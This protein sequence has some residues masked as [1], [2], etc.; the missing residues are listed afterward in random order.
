MIKVS[1]SKQGEL[2][3]AAYFQTMEEAQTWLD[4][5]TSIK[6]F[7]LAPEVVPAQLDEEGNVLVEE[8]VIPATHTVEIADESAKIAAEQALQAKIEAGKKARE[9]CTQVLDL[10]SGDNLSKELTLEQISDMQT[11]FGNIEKALQSARPSLAK[12]MISAVEPD[13]VLI[14][15]ELK[16]AVLALLSEY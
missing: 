12:M 3:N 11:I 13:E 1:I 14:T 9:V 4:Y 10:I 7:R 16:N 5:H 15:T 8:S 2:T 6:S